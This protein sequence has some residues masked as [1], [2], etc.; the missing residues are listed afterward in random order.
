MRHLVGQS[1]IDA[2]LTYADHSEIPREYLTWAAISTIASSIKLNCFIW[3]RGIKFFPNQYI[4][5][6]GPP[7]IGKDE[8]INKIR[9]IVEE[10][11]SIN[12]IKDWH[13][14]QEI[15]EEINNGWGGLGI[16]I[17][18]GNVI[19]GS[20][21]T[22][23]TCTILVPELAV[24]LQQYENMHTLL[25]AWWNQDCFEYKT[26]NNGKISIKNMSVNLL[27]GCVPD[28]VRTMSKDS[29]APITSGFT[30]RTIFVY[31][32]DKY[33]LL[34]DNFGSPT[35]DKTKLKKELVN[36]LQHICQ[37][38]K[39]EISLDDEA[40]KLWKTK[41]GEHN[42]RGN[43]DSDA[44]QNFKAR[45]SSH[46]VKTAIAI[47]ISESDSLQ[48][49]RDQLA[50]AIGLIEGVRDK[51]DIVFR[52][53]GESSLASSQ[54][55]ILDYLDAVGL[56]SYDNILRHMYRDATEEQVTTI[57][58][59]LKKVGMIIETQQGNKLIYESINRINIQ[60]VKP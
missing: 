57:L 9:P 38:I 33:Q 37:N 27:G 17:R 41:Y 45:I 26:K 59:L 16:N 2:F 56:A 58:I 19:G 42:K 29:L 39:G 13:T 23:H 36:D 47:S 48:I 7:G 35:T 52:S 55:K 32:T 44:S 43:N 54:R 53:V 11:Q 15:I 25:C 3:Y 34:A 5:F 28:Y 31:A 60:G 51:V 20:L 21:N 30:A 1:W 14:P 24:F 22:D 40:K 4:I 49:T 8:A 46:I 10:A 12:Y 50:R 6:V 18:P